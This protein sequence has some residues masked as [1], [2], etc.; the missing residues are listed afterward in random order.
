MK[1][2]TKETIKIY[3]QHVKKFKFS[4]YFVLFF[5]MG[6][7]AINAI[8]P[9][10]FKSF[11]DT[12]TADLPKD[13]VYE[14]LF[15]ILVTILFFELLQWLFWRIAGFTNVYFQT[16]VMADLDN[17]SFK[18][19]H[20]HSFFFFNNNFTGSLVKRLN[21]FS[22]AFE[23][24][25]DRLVYDIV[26]I[27]VNIA[28]ITTVLSFKNSI[29]GIAISTWL[30]IYIF[31]NIFVAK[32]KMRYDL[33][34]STAQTK[35]TG[36]LADTITNNANV[37]LFEGYDRE[38]E[39]FGGLNDKVRRARKFSWN[40]ETFF[41]SIQAFLMIILQFGFFYIG[42]RLWRQGSFTL[43]DF[44]LLQSYVLIVM[45]RVWNFGNVLRRLYR[46]FADAEEMTEILNTP[47]DIVDVKNAK[48]LVV[49]RGDIE[50]NRVVFCYYKTRKVLDNLSLT[51]KAKEKVALIGPSGAGKTT[52]VKLLLRNHD[53][54]G[55][56][57]LIDGQNISRVTQTS[58]WHNISLVPQDPILFHRSLLENIRYGQPSASDQDVIAAAKAANCHEFIES[59][60]EGYQTYVGERGVKLSG[61]ER[62]RVAIARAILRNSP[63]LVLDEATSSLDSA[64]EGLI[65]DALGKLMQNKTVI[66][67]AHRLSTIRKV[68]RI[69]FVDEGGIKESGR[70]EE[71]VKQKD[72]HYRRLWELQAGGF[73]A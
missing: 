18:Y 70:H 22:R 10:Y 12:L 67:I 17:T 25:A 60:P 69:I 50:F 43:G 11:F 55:G 32:Y 65:Q 35:A 52:I 46:N 5:I 2:F 9:L 51:I 34:A 24:I 30:V 27:I 64:S 33:A 44:V 15:S 48:E 31:I 3:W 72:G 4:F 6:A 21:Y 47:H 62:Q 19:L 73:I 29:L 59:F 39:I 20:R 57:I 58:L 54:D 68:D 40:M 61:G 36:D 71:L 49:D 14:S 1:Y 63:I 23:G 8:V 28:I 45:M 53:L 42:L 37:K 66:V 13:S 38:V 16:H 7:S 56:K 26:P 41:E